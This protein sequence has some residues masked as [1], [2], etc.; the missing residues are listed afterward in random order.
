MMAN[1]ACRYVKVGPH[2]FRAWHFSLVAMAAAMALGAKPQAAAAAGFQF[3]E[4]DDKSLG[5]WE[6]DRPVLVFNHGDVQPPD[7]V[8][9]PP[10]SNYVHP[11]YGLDGE[12]LTDDFPADHV[13]HRGLHWAWPHVKVGDNPRDMSLWKYEGIRYRF[14]RWLAQESSDGVAKLGVENSWV[15]GDKSVV[16]EEAWLVVHPETEN[17]RAIDLTF[18]WTP[19]EPITLWGAEGKSYGGL[20]LRYAPREETVTT[21]PSGRAKEDL[22][23]TKLPWADLSAK[24]EGAARPSGAAVFVDPQHPNAPLEWMTRDY[25]LLAVGWPGV[26]KITLEPGETATCRYRV[27][28]HRGAPAA[29]QLADQYE[30]YR[31]HLGPDNSAR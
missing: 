11:L 29:D 15:V 8:K 26:N 6:G 31:K 16:R 21:V 18:K 13:H 28:V 3:K 4:I 24:F 20:V 23:V 22:L 12:V 30:A 1:Y 17:G 7:G 25:G 5:L 14:E 19:D 27:L 10:H 2:V 9:A